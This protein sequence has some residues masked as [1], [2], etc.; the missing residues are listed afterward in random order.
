MTKD[1]L[2]APKGFPEFLQKLWGLYLNDSFQSV[3][4]PGV[5]VNGVGFCKI[6]GIVWVE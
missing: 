4:P 6:R 5:I 3:K 1:F 2:G